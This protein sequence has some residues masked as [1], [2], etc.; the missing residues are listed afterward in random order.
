MLTNFRRQT[1]TVPKAT[2]L[3]VAQEVS[4]D[5]VGS[6]NEENVSDVSGPVKPPRE[7][8]KK[9]LYEQL[10]Q[11]KLEHLKPEERRQ[12]EAV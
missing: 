5:L 4:E 6:K 1:L 3:G 7:R 10:V 12:I 2:V 11:G 8:K 9:L